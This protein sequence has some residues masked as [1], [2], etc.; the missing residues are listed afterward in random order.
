M[1]GDAAAVPWSCEAYGQEGNELGALCFI[2]GD[3]GRRVCES[4]KACHAAMTQER[5][6]VFD[7]INEMAADGDP[8]AVYLAGEFGSPEEILGGDEST[9]DLLRRPAVVS[10][11]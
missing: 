5:Q 6:R 4:P 7:R 2:A 10:R 11:A 3:L 1:T 9:A 8:T